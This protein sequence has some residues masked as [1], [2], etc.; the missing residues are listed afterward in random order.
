MDIVGPILLQLVLIALNAIFAC[1]EIAVLSINETKVVKLA[2]EGNRKAKKLS[3]LIADPARFLAT[4]QVAITLSGFLGSA[5][6]ADNFSEPIVQGLIKM[7]VKVPAATLDVIAVVAITLLLSFVTLVFGEL[8]PKR[9]A[10]QKTEQLALGLSGS[11][12]LISKIFAPLVMLLTVCTNGVLRMM[13][14]DPHASEEQVSEEDILMMADA[15]TEKGIIDEE[16]NELIQNV[17]EFDD[18]TVGQAMTHRTELVHL[19]AEESMEEW[20]KTIYEVPHT[21]YP[22]CDE[23]VDQVI[24]I[25]DSRKFLRMPELTKKS[26]METAVVKPLL[27]S[28][29]MK[30]DDLFR[31]M[32]MTKKHFAVVID[33]FGGTDGIV[34]INDLIE[35]LVG[36]LEETPTDIIEQDE[37]TYKIEGDTELNK[38]ERELKVD[39]ESTAA[40]LSGWIVEQLGGIPQKGDEF[41]Y[42]KFAVKI[43]KVDE[44]RVLEAVIK[45]DPPAEEE[46]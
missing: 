21:F 45:I 24:G 26:V 29:Q 3:K 39:L 18:L 17:F 43:T 15:G 20:K 12:S 16:E 23:N 30:T 36:E 8:V 7:G 31:Q 35:L 44:K 34:T 1:A 11:I 42:E 10:M 13:G 25:L 14:I 33:E 5:F 9:V 38:V 46:E 37:F 40:T 41:H 19:W 6:A 2:E 28:S 27:A 32:K 22:I 4:I